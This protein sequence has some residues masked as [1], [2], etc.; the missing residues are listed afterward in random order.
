M[1]YLIKNGIVVNEGEMTQRD[2]AISNGLIADHASPDAVIVDATGCL[3]MPGII[4]THVHFRDPGLTNKADM[5]TESRAAIAGGVT[6]VIDM[7]NTLPQTTTLELLDQKE[8]IAADRCLVNYGFM[9]GATNENIEQLTAIEPTRY[10]AIK[11]FLG[12]STGNMLVNDEQ[13][14]DLLFKQARKLIVAHCEEESIIENNRNKYRLRYEGS[15]RETAALHPKIRSTE[16]CYACTK[17]AI[18]RAKRFDTRF[19][20]AHISTAAELDLLTNLPL[21]KKL[22]TAEVTPNHLYFSDLDYAKY[23][24]LI[25][26]NPSIKSGTIASALWDALCQGLIDTVA[27][28]HAPHLLADKEKPYF[29]APSG[30][31]SIQNSLQ[32]M[33]EL[34]DKSN[35]EFEH[36]MPLLVY[37]MCH[38]PAMLF[39]IKNRGFIRT[40]YAADIVIVKRGAQ[41]KVTPENLYYKCGWSPL[42]GHTFHNQI[43]ETFINGIPYKEGVKNAQPLQFEK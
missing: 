2:V 18:T 14:L 28:D 43:I 35:I 37:K 40:G 33:M 12:S 1:D 16:A 26:C 10:A 4:D 19:H 15:A 3:V 6:S 23:G 27:T 5:G 8:Q 38:N 39:G 25:K 29:A 11:L 32:M 20:V 34:A 22:I 9:L 7:P 42:T 41:T 21:D 30:I 17:K 24:N 13:R 31:P 36:I